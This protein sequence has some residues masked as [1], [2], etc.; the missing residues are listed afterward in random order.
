MEIYN[1][2]EVKSY[3]RILRKKSTPAEVFFWQ[4]IRNNKFKGKKF[5]RLYSVGKYIID[6]YCPEEKLGIE[7]DGEYHFYP[8][9]ILYDKTRTDYIESFGI[10][11]LRFENN[12]ILFNIENVL[13]EISKN[14]SV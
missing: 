6:F 2:T 8:E 12:E 11:I 4:I 10:K 7:L 14:F 3:R 1:K 13:S 9:Q 5:R